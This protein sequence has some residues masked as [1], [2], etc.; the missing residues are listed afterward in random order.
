MCFSPS[1][2]FG[3]SGVLLAIGTISVIKAQTTPQRIFA[4]IPLIFSVQQFFEGLLW[5]ALLYPVYAHWERTATYTFLVFAQV[6]WPVFLP[7]AI[8]LLEKEQVRKNILMLF[9]GVGIAV[10]GYLAYCMLN[11]N[12]TGIIDGHH[13]RYDVDFPGSNQWYS[14]IFYFIPT[15]ISPFIS[16]VK[17]MKLFGL[18]IILSY[19]VTRVFYHYYVISVWCYFGAILSIVVLFIIMQLRKEQIKM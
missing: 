5:L 15:A 7:F 16:S 17:R 2:S 14:G 13:I 19:I 6:V 1:A 8:M 4:F 18:L 12:V 3:A 10:G 9:L 11:Y